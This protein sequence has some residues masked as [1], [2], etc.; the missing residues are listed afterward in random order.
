[1]TFITREEAKEANDKKY[2]E[3]DHGDLFADR[4]ELSAQSAASGGVIGPTAG[5]IGSVQAAEAVKILAGNKSAL[6]GRLL[7]VDLLNMDF[8]TIDL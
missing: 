2:A 4:E 7:S 8:N 5:V 6:D 3:E 1:M